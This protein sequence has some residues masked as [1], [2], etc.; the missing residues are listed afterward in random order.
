MAGTLEGRSVLVVDDDK[1]IV[2]VLSSVLTERGAQVSV[3][4]D[5]EEAVDMAQDLEPDLVILDAMLPKRS[6]FL[7]LEKLKRGTGGQHSSLVIMITANE[8]KR[9]QKWAV[10]LGVDGYFNKPFRMDSLVSMV[11]NLLGA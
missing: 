3:A 2:D 5:G 6:G 11:E 8:G 7:V 9:H 4:V 1:E 10:I